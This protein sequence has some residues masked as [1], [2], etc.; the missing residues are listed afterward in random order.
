MSIERKSYLLAKEPGVSPGSEFFIAGEDYEGSDIWIHLTMC[1][2]Y[3]CVR[4]YVIDR[5]FYDCIL[6]AYID[7]G[8]L[9]ISFEGMNCTATTDDVVFMDLRQ[10]HCYA[11]ADSLNFSW[12]HLKG[13]LADRIYNQYRS[14]NGIILR[15]ERCLDI[16]RNIRRILSAFKT[17][18][19]LDQTELSAALYQTALLTLNT[20]STTTATKTEQAVTVAIEY[21]KYHISNPIT[22]PDIA[23]A[24]HMSKYHFIRT[25]KKSTGSSPYEY[26]QRLRMDAAKHLLH[27]TAKTVSEIAA[28]VGYQTEMGFSSAFTEKVGISPGRYRNSPF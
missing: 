18:Q 23:A 26:L 7:Q 22:L 10:A 5:P 9:E 6:M 8:G 11:A 20:G 16:S 2:Q 17:G 24:V 21:M 3:H 12:L 27:T 19:M 25:F 15:N 14:T 4:G 1:G 28:A 13:E